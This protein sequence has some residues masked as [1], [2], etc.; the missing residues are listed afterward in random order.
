MNFKTNAIKLYNIKDVSRE[1]WLKFR[2]D[3]IGGSDVA[4]IM[5]L[6]KYRTPLDVYISKVEEIPEMDLVDNEFIYWG[7]VLEDIV[8]KEFQKRNPEY[9]VFKSSFM[10]QH[11]EHKFMVANVDRLLYHPEH[12]WGV[13][14]IKTASEYRNGHFEGETIPEEYLLQ[15]QHYV[16]TMGVNYSFLAA[17]IGGNKYKQF[18]IEKNEEL[19]ETLIELEKDFWENHVLAQSPP[20]IDGSEAATTFLKNMYGPEHA[21]SDNISIPLK[22]D[23]EKWLQ[24]Y[25]EA[26]EEEKAIK[27]KKENAINHL[28]QEMGN[29]Q[30]ATLGETEIKWTV[31]NTNRFDQKQF[32]KDHP[33]LSEKYI[34]PSQSRRF[35]IK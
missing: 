18:K 21:E 22:K 25:H 2:Q 12:G 15:T 16:G 4:A 3:G 6:N 9:K 13:L 11:P 28:K 10:W 24:I 17:L 23:S 1:K 14:E 20:E 5:G 19:I 34:K 31:V 27:L 29:F 8:A 33:E 26:T 7:N 30:K 35:A 32:K